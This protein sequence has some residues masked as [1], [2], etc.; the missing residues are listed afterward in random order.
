MLQRRFVPVPSIYRRVKA[1]RTVFANSGPPIRLL[2]FSHSLF[3]IFIL[4]SLIYYLYGVIHQFAYQS[5]VSTKC[6]LRG[7]PLHRIFKVNWKTNQQV[8]TCIVLRTNAA[9]NLYRFF[10]YIHYS[11]TRAQ[12]NKCIIICSCLFSFEL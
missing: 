4:Y 11:S 9:C 8:N 1:H 12:A 6:I 2:I 7:V 10:V 3:F 5:D